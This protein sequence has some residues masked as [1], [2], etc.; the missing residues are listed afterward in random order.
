MKA[1]VFTRLVCVF[2]IYPAFLSCEGKK[3]HSLHWTLFCVGGCLRC[4]IYKLSKE[5]ST[6]WHLVMRS[7]FM[8]LGI[9]TVTWSS[10]VLI[11]D[12]WCCVVNWSA[13]V[14]VYHV[15]GLNCIVFLWLWLPD[16]KRTDYCCFVNFVHIRSCDGVGRLLSLRNLLLP[17]LFNPAVIGGKKAHLQVHATRA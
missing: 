11:V 7:F 8:T 15:G 5:R 10:H 12:S 16:T 9:V 6:L 17:L 1:N 3:N 14:L 4:F 2:F 13:Y